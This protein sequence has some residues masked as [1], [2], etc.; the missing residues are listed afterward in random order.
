MDRIEDDS[1][2]TPHERSS[3]VHKI[4]FCKFSKILDSKQRL[5]QP[6]SQSSNSFRQI[7]AVGILASHM[8]DIRSTF[9]QLKTIV[10]LNQPQ[11][12]S[13]SVGMTWQDDT[14]I[15]RDTTG[16]KFIDVINKIR[17]AIVVDQ[18]VKLWLAL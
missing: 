7:W 16:P 17:G 2:V 9:G 5:A 6:K 18:I 14:P 1:I 4:G 12:E 8:G 11:L 15:K 10:G 3:T 13:Q